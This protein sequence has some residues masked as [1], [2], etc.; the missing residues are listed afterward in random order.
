MIR[1]T[2]VWVFSAAFWLLFT[3]VHVVTLR[4]MPESWV[5]AL[6]RGW[7]RTSLVIAGIRMEV[8]GEHTFREPGAR[9]VI[10]NHE[11]GLDILWCAAFTCPGALG[12]G[13]KEVIW[14]PLLNLAWWGL[15]F[16]RIDRKN[17]VRALAALHGV[18]ELIVRDSRTLVM[19][20]E[21]TRTADG[22]MGPFKK[23]AFHIAIEAQVPIHPVVVA[24]AFE[25]MPKGQ[26][27]MTPGVIRIR[28]LPPVS[29]QGLSSDQLNALVER[30]RAQMLAAHQEMHR[31]LPPG[32]GAR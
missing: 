12:I 13:K 9:V 25:L 16:I 30:V 8:E 10:C 2:L 18:S 15:R 4:S 28:F 21:G 5:A 14:V 6:I 1:T 27:S 26:F 29:T 32:S 24:G 20:P 17:H 3:V 7:A 19:A 23:G 31:L 11:S 22:K